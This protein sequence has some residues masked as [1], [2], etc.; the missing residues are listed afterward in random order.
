MD[1]I[2]R[3]TQHGVLTPPLPVRFALVGLAGAVV[4]YVLLWSMVELADTDDIQGET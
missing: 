1:P 3:G 2:L 4:Y